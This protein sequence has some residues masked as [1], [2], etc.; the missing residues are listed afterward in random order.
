MVITCIIVDYY[1]AAGQSRASEQGK[2]AEKIRARDCTRKKR[3]EGKQKQVRFPVTSN[4]FIPC[5]LAVIQMELHASKLYTNLHHTT[6]TN[7]TFNSLLKTALMLS[8]KTVEYEYPVAP[9]SH[10]L[11]ACPAHALPPPAPSPLH[12]RHVTKEGAL[13]S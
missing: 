7:E 1:M 3:R 13:S 12:H 6:R 8:W 9:V 11:T 10:V 4:L 5:P 2:V